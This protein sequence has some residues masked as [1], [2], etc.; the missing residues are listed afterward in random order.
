MIRPRSAHTGLTWTRLELD[1]IGFYQSLGLDNDRYILCGPAHVL[2]QTAPSIRSA[3]QHLLRMD[4]IGMAG[5]CISVRCVC[6]CV[7]GIS[8]RRVLP[9]AMRA[10]R[11]SV[12]RSSSA[13]FHVR[14]RRTNYVFQETHSRAL[15]VVLPSNRPM[16][17]YC[18]PR[19]TLRCCDNRRFSTMTQIGIV[20]SKCGRD[21]SLIRRDLL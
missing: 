9:E 18:F 19:P 1:R 2:L 14:G 12:G 17:E 3:W 6:V 4:R 16:H 13:P 11:N 7:L 20:L 15:L 5:L 21:R 8:P 10:R